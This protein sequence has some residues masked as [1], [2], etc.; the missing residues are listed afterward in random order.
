M[1]YITLMTARHEPM[2]AD[3]DWVTNGMGRKGNVEN[4][5]H[6]VYLSIFHEIQA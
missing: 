3:P 2:A 4:W 6:Y 1:Q 5:R